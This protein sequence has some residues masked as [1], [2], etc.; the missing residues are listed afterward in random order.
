VCHINLLRCFSLSGSKGISQQQYFQN[1]ARERIVCS[2]LRNNLRWFGKGA[3]RL[4]KRIFVGSSAADVEIARAVS[5]ELPKT[6]GVVGECRTQAFPTSRTSGLTF[7]VGGV[8]TLTPYL[9]EH[10]P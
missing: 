6:I 10:T 4:M 3:A 7:D 1:C 8:R 2:M 5:D 9:W